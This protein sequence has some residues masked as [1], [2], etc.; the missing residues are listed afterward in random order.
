[1]FDWLR[2]RWAPRPPVSLEPLTPMQQ[3]AQDFMA[4][5]AWSEAQGLHVPPVQFI[6]NKDCVDWTVAEPVL[7]RLIGPYRDEE[8]ERELF[9][10]NARLVPQ[11]L[12]ALGIPFRLTIGWFDISGEIHHRHDQAQLK[13]L[14][15]KDP[16]LD[17]SRGLDLHV[18]LTS[19]AFE[20]LDVCLPTIVAA[21]TQDPN[22]ARGILYLSNQDPNPSVT[23]HP[24]TVGEEFLFRI[25][26]VFGIGPNA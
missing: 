22:L 25:G 20:V 6:V 11:L 14:L 17:T 15:E 8:I 12:E 13:R 18:W 3:Y 26:A 23:Y 21:R 7:Q 19:P 16:S 2:R 5:S 4:A 1:M 9:A 24:T 10:M